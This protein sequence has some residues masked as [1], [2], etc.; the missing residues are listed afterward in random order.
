MDLGSLLLGLALLLLV[1][2]IVARPILERRD[3]PDQEISRADQ[4]VAERESLLA[5]LRDLDFDHATGKISDEDYTPQRAQFVAQGVAILKHLDALGPA[6]PEHAVSAEDEIERAVAARRRSSLERRA[7]P[8]ARAVQSADDLIEAAVAARRKPA[9]AQR[10]AP[11]PDGVT[12][13]NCGALAKPGDRFCP[14]CGR[15]L[16]RVCPTCAHPVQ[17]GDRFCAACGAKLQPAKAAG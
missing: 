14:K 11:A 6:L 8:A 12:C 17:P 10:P 3:M 1:A 16:A 5:A 13:S 15:V 2:F 4:L 7:T 9:P